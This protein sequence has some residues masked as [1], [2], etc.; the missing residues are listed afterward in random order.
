ME[1]IQALTGSLFWATMVSV[2]LDTASFFSIGLMA[3]KSQLLKPVGSGLNLIALF[4]VLQIFL[5]LG[6]EEHF[7]RASRH[8]NFFSWMIFTFAALRLG[9]YLYGDLFVV[10]WQAGK[11]SGCFQKHYH[12]SCPYR[13]APHPVEGNSEHQCHLTHCNNHRSYCDDRSRFSKYSRQHARRLDNSPG[14]TSE[15]R[16]LDLGGRTRRTRS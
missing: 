13:R 3:R 12:G 11:F 2:V 1:F 7:P 6:A 16:R 8:L 15:A 9:L 4:I 5:H 14:E 10:R